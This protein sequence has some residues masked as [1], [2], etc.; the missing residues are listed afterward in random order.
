MR[1][2]KEA[3][4]RKK[5]FLSV[6]LLSVIFSGC[7]T[8]KVAQRALDGE[9]KPKPTEELADKELEGPVGDIK[10]AKDVLE[11]DPDKFERSWEIW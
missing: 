3:G 5:L 2:L 9:L 1:S 8:L 11:Y 10:N 4:M 7:E 6:I